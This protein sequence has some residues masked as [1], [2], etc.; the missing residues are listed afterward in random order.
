MNLFPIEEIIKLVPEEN[1]NS[2][3]R[4][5]SYKNIYYNQN[6]FDLVEIP[7]TCYDYDNQMDS[8]MKILT[9]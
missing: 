4:L 6:Y 3:Y 8:R 1:K 7:I 2:I 9:K 5:Y